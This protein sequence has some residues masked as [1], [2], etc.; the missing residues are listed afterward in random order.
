MSLCLGV[1][2]EEELTAFFTSK[3]DAHAVMGMVDWDGDHVLTFTELAWFI[4]QKT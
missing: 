4:S 1:L 2:D 3:E